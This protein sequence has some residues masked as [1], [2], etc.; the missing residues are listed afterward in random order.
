MYLV[1]S[2]RAN[3]NNNTLQGKIRIGINKRIDSIEDIP[4][5][6][7]HAPNSRAPEYIEKGMDMEKE[8]CSIVVQCFNI[9]H[10]SFPDLLKYD[11]QR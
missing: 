6:N 5:I 2:D 7:T 4:I 3:L 11:W 9:L 1:I 8:Y 10:F